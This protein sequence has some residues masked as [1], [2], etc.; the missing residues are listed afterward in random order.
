M[1]FLDDK[2]RFFGKLSIVD[3]FVVILIVACIGAVGLKMQA[4][5][6]VS[7]GDRTITYDVRVENIREMSVN[8]IDKNREGLIDA[9]SKKELGS[10]INVSSSPSR[11]LVQKNDGTFVFTEYDNRYDI[12]VTLQASG[13]ET[14]DGYFTSSGKQISVGDTIQIKNAASQYYG[15]IASVVVE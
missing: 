12:I 14:D 3:L 15:E 4:S 7:G 8:A 13:T 1:K 2:G 10:V 9:D 11:Q 5:K 6:S